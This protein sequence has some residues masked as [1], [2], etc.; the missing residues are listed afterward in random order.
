[1]YE[2]TSYF[3]AAGLIDGSS[4]PYASCMKIAEERVD[5]EI[6]VKRA[7]KT[8]NIRAW[9]S[10]LRRP[11]AFC[12][13][14]SSTCERGN[15]DRRKAIHTKSGRD[16]DRCPPTLGTPSPHLIRREVPSQTPAHNA[17]L[18]TLHTI[19]EAYKYAPSHRIV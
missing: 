8:E 18:I 11:G 10:H 17:R 19:F 2:C 16:A 15:D 14:P 3:T 6:V 13:H 7:E 5:R 1:M 12:V 9:R 4:R